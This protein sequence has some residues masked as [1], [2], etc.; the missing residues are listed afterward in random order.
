VSFDTADSPVDDL[1][2]DLFHDNAPISPAAQAVLLDGS[3]ASLDGSAA[4]LDGSAASLTATA[5]APLGFSLPGLSSLADTTVA[6]LQPQPLA[7]ADADT[8]MNNADAV[9]DEGELV[10]CMTKASS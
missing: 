2:T 8:V 4:S 6:V 3:A 1:D 7:Q 10:E 5:P 9:H